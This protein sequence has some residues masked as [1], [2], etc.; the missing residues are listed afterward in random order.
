[1]AELAGTRLPSGTFTL[2]A[3]ARRRFA[4]SVLGDPAADPSVDALWIFTSGFPGLG[5]DLTEVFALAGCSMTEDGPMLG[6]C[7]LTLTR[8]IEPDRPYE[9]SGEILGVERKTGRRTGTFDLLR[10]RVALS[11]EHGEA[12]SAVATY[13]LPMR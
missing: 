9:A 11:D 12:A 6:G 1:V 7:E 2:T 5:I 4:E 8:A 10:V 3:D 13:V